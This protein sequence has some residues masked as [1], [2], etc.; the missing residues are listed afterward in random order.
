MYAPYY[1]SPY[2]II[3]FIGLE[4]YKPRITALNGYEEPKDLHWKSQKRKFSVLRLNHFDLFSYKS[5]NKHQR[6]CIH[7]TT[8]VSKR[9]SRSFYLHCFHRIYPRDEINEE[10]GN[11]WTSKSSLNEH[12]QLFTIYQC[13]KAMI[14][15]LW[16]TRKGCSG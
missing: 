13:W 11:L 3:Y 10:F 15:S 7:A 12:S 4:T 8:T 9:L 5:S 6:N 14:H 16:I 2:H 1:V